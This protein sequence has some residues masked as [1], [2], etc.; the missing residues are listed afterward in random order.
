MSK[1]P[2]RIFFPL[3]I[4]WLPNWYRASQFLK[5]TDQGFILPYGMHACKTRETH[6]RMTILEALS[7]ALKLNEQLPISKAWCEELTTIWENSV[8]S[9]EQHKSGFLMTDHCS[10]ISK[11]MLLKRFEDPAYSF[12]ERLIELVA[13]LPLQ[14]E[15]LSI[16]V[17]DWLITKLDCR[18]DHCGRFYTSPVARILGRVID[19]SIITEKLAPLLGS[20][21]EIVRS[22]AYITILEAERTLGKRLIKK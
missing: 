2:L 12:R 5:T 6:L 3:Y 8:D 14:K 11:D 1:T 16:D 10:Y 20:K 19:E 15:D 21:N 7:S 9:Y 22:N 13:R 18:Y 4:S 17:I